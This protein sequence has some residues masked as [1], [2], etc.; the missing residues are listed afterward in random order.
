MLEHT[1]NMVISTQSSTQLDNIKSEDLSATYA[2]TNM[3]IQHK[4]DSDF[5]SNSNINMIIIA[6]SVMK[7]SQSTITVTTN[8]SRTASTRTPV[9]TPPTSRIFNKDPIAVRVKPLD[10]QSILPVLSNTSNLLV[11]HQIIEVQPSEFT[12]PS[13]NTTNQENL[14]VLKKHTSAR[15]LFNP[16]TLI[17][18]N[19]FNQQYTTITNEMLIGMLMIGCIIIGVTLSIVFNVMI[20]T[21]S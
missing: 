17:Y 8:S 6:P 1:K 21:M 13:Q 14:I 15:T 4:P 3:A 20:K 9:D 5:D 10:S 18:T 7:K 12:L 2:K 11:D 19:R 16:L